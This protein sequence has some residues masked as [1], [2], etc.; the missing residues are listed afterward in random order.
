MNYSILNFTNFELRD[1]FLK[2]AE[3]ENLTCSRYGLASKPAAIC[4]NITPNDVT[5]IERLFGDKIVI[6]EDTKYKTTITK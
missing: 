1:T 5:I 3:N 6:Q 4:R 2:N